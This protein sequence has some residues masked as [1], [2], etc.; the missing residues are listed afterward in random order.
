MAQ[1]TFEPNLFLYDTP[2]FL[3]PTSFYTHL[4]ACE[5]GTDKIAPKHR[6]L[7]F[8]RRGITQKKAYNIQ[9][10]AKALNQQ[11][12][13]HQIQWSEDVWHVTVMIIF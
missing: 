8:R 2:T 11:P 5:D 3:K 4:P 9:N 13:L 10:T 6:N 1:A 12:M 7:N